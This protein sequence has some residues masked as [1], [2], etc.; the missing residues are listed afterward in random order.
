MKPK[1]KFVLLTFLKSLISNDAAIEG[2][3]KAPWWM[4]LILGVASIALPLI[5]TAVSIGNQ[6]GSDYLTNYI[7]GNEVALTDVALKAKA[8]NVEFRVEGDLCSYYKDNAKTFVSHEDASTPVYTYMSERHETVYV[9]EVKT[10]DTNITKEVEFMLFYTSE[11]DKINDLIKDIETKHTYVLGKDTLISQ[12]DYVDLADENT[13]YYLPSYVIIHE[14]G[15]YVLLTQQSST[16]KYGATSYVTDW[17]NTADGDLITRIL[18]VEGVEEADA[19]ITNRNYVSA[20]YGNFKGVVNEAF[21]TSR[22]QN[23][24]R[25]TLIFAGVYAALI[26]LM[27]LMTFLLTRGKNNPFN[28]LNYGITLK[29]A[30]W[31]SLS[32]AILG[33]ALGFWLTKYA[34]YIFIILIGLRIMW[35]SLKQFRPYQ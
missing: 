6:K 10:E 29:V 34:P 5:P 22:N 21:I 4:A 9:E 23:L 24:L 19:K 13:R 20:V 26:L 2:A 8:D 31:A 32:P 33:M 25:S 35:I 1:A 27:G 11:S 17:K 14:T 16:T 3:K 7:G 28:Y 12:Q 30:C 15:I 18:S